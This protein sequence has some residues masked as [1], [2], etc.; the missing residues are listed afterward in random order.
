MTK[1][2][3]VDQLSK[4]KYP[5]FSK[6]I[7]SFGMLKDILIS[8]DSITI[9]LSQPTNESKILDEIK[10]NVIDSISS[11]NHSDK[12][13]IINMIPSDSL[14]KTNYSEELLSQPKVLAFSHFYL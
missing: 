12:E 1:Q 6:D 9:N 11:I 13:I 5:G 4:V 14:K 8:E 2:N 10:S 7:I 3:V